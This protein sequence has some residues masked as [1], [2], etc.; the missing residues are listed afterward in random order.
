[1]ALFPLIG[2]LRGP[3]PAVCE[4]TGFGVKAY[5]SPKPMWG[6]DQDKNCSFFQLDTELDPPHLV[7]GHYLNA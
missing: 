5:V 4:E 7:N 3:A 1:M 2:V 6:L